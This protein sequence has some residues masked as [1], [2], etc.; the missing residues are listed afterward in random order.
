MGD[1]VTRSKIAKNWPDIVGDSLSRVSRPV[2]VKNRTLFVDVY[3]WIWIDSFLFQQKE[4]LNAV[5]EEV[6]PNAIERLYFQ[7]REPTGQ[8]PKKER[9]APKSRMV[10]LPD[11]EIREL[12]DRLPE[13]RDGELREIVRRVFLKERAR[14]YRN[15]SGRLNS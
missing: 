7:I 2:F 15:L 9:P 13:I 4:I 6:G 10:L 8:I 1:I 12:E 5:S 11:H 14:F 3:P